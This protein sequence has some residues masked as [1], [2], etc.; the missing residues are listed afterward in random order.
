[1][2]NRGSNQPPIKA[3]TI[4]MQRS[5]TIPKPVPRTILPASHTAMISTM[6]MAR[7]LWPDMMPSSVIRL[8][9]HLVRADQQRLWN[10]QPERFSSL[11][12]DDQLELRRLLDGQIGRLGG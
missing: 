4:P 6:M 7:R 11:E 10:R 9:N 12:V 8:P 1:M 3:P 2:P 5:A